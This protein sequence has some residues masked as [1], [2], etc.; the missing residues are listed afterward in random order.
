MASNKYDWEAAVKAATQSANKQKNTGT[1]QTTSGGT[2]KGNTGATQ[3]VQ[4]AAQQQQSGTLKTTSGGTVKSSGS[5]SSNKGTSGGTTNHTVKITY[6]P[7]TTTTNIET[8]AYKNLQNSG[9]NTVSG[10]SANL[11]AGKAEPVP[12]PLQNPAAGYEKLAG[13][14]TLPANRYQLPANDP[15]FNYE[16]AINLLAK[17]GMTE[18][19][20]NGFP[21][22]A[23][24]LGGGSYVLPYLLNKPDDYEILS[25][26]NLITVGDY[27]KAL[28]NGTLMKGNE[29]AYNDWIGT[30]A[31]NDNVVLR[32]PDRYKEDYTDEDLSVGSGS[33]SVS[34]PAINGA[35]VTGGATVDK[36]NPNT[37]A[38]PD[39]AQGIIDAQSAKYQ[40]LIDALAAQRGTVNDQYDANAAD[41]YA[42]YR[43]ADLALP[44]MLAGTATGIA[45]SMTLQ[46]NLNYQNNLYGNELERA[47]ALNN[48]LAQENQYR[49]DADLQ[50]AQTA[51]EWAQ[52]LYQQ[53]MNEQALQREY[54]MQKLAADREYQLALMQIQNKGNTTGGNS[55][56]KGSGSTSSTNSGNSGG[57]D[58][59]VKE[60]TT[61]KD[62]KDYLQLQLGM[63]NNMTKANIERV[64]KDMYVAG[65]ISKDLAKGVAQDFGF[66]LYL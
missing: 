31:K 16:K 44:E 37:G 20:L 50:A 27:K 33:A 25:G 45:D 59:D 13:A 40:A 12:D 43:R 29:S 53:Q 58:N 11:G 30:V 14:Q 23:M 35:P 17:Y 26:S 61:V 6:K 41:L 22:E 1:Y 9:A 5:T 56:N 15:G 34:S 54:E 55:G 49:A 48:L 63:G 66:T 36:V 3:A 47:N 62:V 57:N 19:D 32:D 28:L 2:V 10:A 64:L 39:Y 51:A 38:L 65:A 21:I 42:Q 60:K 18:A 24:Y 7:K 46:N 52:L 4:S 8:E